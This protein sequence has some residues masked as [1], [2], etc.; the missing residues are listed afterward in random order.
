MQRVRLVRERVRLAVKQV[1]TDDTEDAH[2]EVE[3]NILSRMQKWKKP[4]TPPKLVQ[5]ENDYRAPGKKKKLKNIVRNEYYADA[6]AY[7]NDR[8]P[9][10][11]YRLRLLG[12]SYK[13]IAEIFQVS[14]NTLQTWR[15][16]FPDFNRAWLEGGPEAD[17]VVAQALFR[18]AVGWSH[19]DEKIITD[20][21]GG[22]TRVPI[23][24]K[25]APDVNAIKF[26]LTN[27]QGGKHGAWR[28][29][30]EV[31]H[32][33]N[34]PPVLTPIPVTPQQMIPP[35]TLEAGS[36]VKIPD[37]ESLSESWADGENDV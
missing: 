7:N 31:N 11:V 4:A 10:M 19:A 20:K 15:N 17:A 8:H 16:N 24:T 12:T 13:E 26:W 22:Y 2:E 28:E 27:R 1:Q 9:A 36:F 6:F 30:S 29:K 14:I 5:D 21:D 35:P 23:T 3:T 18:K 34:M 33:I 25:F 32:N 37:N